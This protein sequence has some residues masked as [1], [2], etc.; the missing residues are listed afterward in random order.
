GK[1][2]QSIA[3]D[4]YDITQYTPLPLP[5][6]GNR[7]LFANTTLLTDAAQEPRFRVVLNNPRPIWNWVSRERPVAGSTIDNFGTVTPTDYFVRVRVCVAGM[8]ESNCR[9]Y[10]NGNYKPVGLLQDYGENDSMLFG[11][12]TGSYNRNI[13]GG[14]LRK[15]VG[16][17]RNEIDPND[18]R[19]LGTNPGIIR[20]L[21]ALRTAGFVGSYEYT[22]PSDNCGWITNGP[23]TTGRCRMWG[24][25]TAEM[26]YEALR[27]FA[28]KGAPT[29]AFDTTGGLDGSLGLSRDTWDNPY[30]P[31][32]PICAKPFQTVISDI[33]N[34]Y[35]TD[36]LPGTA[37]GSFSGD[38]SGLNVSTLGNTIWNH[39]FGGPALHFI[40]QSG[41][42]N[43]FA[44]TPK[45]VTS[46]GNIRGLAP[47]EPT[48][49]GGYYAGSISYFG[50]INDL[51]PAAGNQRLQTFAVA[52]A[53]PLP[54]IEIPVGGKRVTIVPFAKSVGGCMITPG[55]FTFKPTNQIV[56][57]YVESITPTS[58]SFRVNFEDVEQGADHDMDAIVRY[59]Y[60]V[61]PDD[62]VTVTLT[63]EYAAGCIIQHMGYVISGTTQ[64][65]TYFEVRDIDTAAASD[66]DYP[67]DT[68]VSGAPWNDGQPL[69]LTASRTFT[70]GSTAGATILRDPLWFAAKWG[71][72]QDQNNDNLPQGAEWDADGDG[73]PDNYFLVT[74]A[75]TLRQQLGKAFDEVQRR[76]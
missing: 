9:L 72:F 55:P 37:F 13:D 39:E 11:L 32:K 47:E 7:H 64:D 34:N 49:L 76:A 6:P 57:F 5:T 46:F 42:L 45:L 4:G 48:K 31:G 63:S 41:G 58:G 36:Q 66:V 18:G 22:D 21:D 10:P 65:G 62:T 70:P 43:D 61:N 35:D 75:L 59:E 52:L 15:K 51:N 40:G 73:D 60:V 71:G 27:Y 38:V 53:S 24:N 8:I 67:F 74:N 1:Q 33:H 23:I 29:A 14:V 30:G 69:P 56:D 50:H 54:K 19:F 20:T 25:P 2:Y 16:T 28:G 17:I 12:I 44:P 3:I 68:P 26:M